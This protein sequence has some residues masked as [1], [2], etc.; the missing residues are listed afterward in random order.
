MRAAVE[1]FDRGHGFIASGV[2][3]FLEGLAVLDGDGVGEG[4]SLDLEFGDAVLDV[5]GLL[6]AVG[7]GLLDDSGAFGVRGLEFG[8]L[9]LDRLDVRLLPRS[10][11]LQR[12]SSRSCSC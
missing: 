12:R 4:F 11:A 10:R 6:V 7:L 1:N 3:E 5:G 8:E 9:L 2:D